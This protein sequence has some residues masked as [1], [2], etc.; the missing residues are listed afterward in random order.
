MKTKLTTIKGHSS[1]SGDGDNVAHD[2]SMPIDREPLV[3]A[4]VYKSSASHAQIDQEYAT[5]PE[6][7]KIEQD[8]KAIIKSREQQTIKLEPSARGATQLVEGQQSVSPQDVLE[9]PRRALVQSGALLPPYDPGQMVHLFEHSNSLR[10]NVDA[11]K[12]NIDGF[13]HRLEPTINLESDDLET[14]ISTAMF[15]DRVL[16]GDD[17][18][19]APSTEE[20][21][22]KIAEIKQQ[23]AI[24]KI[25]LDFFFQNAVMNESFITLR[26]KT[27]QDQEI[28]G[29]AYWEVLRDKEGNIAQFILVPSHTVRLN[30]QGP[31]LIPIEQNVQATAITFTKRVSRRRFRTFVQNIGLNSVF[32]KEFGDPRIISAKTGM[33]WPSVEGMQSEEGADAREANEVIHFAVHSTRSP[34]GVPRWIGALLAVLGSRQAE[35]VNFLYFDNKSVPPMAMIVTGGRVT[36]DTEARIRDFIESEVKGRNSFHNILILEAETDK[37][38][39]P[40]HTGRMKIE[41][42]PL[43]QAIHNDALFQNYDKENIQK[44]GQSFRL[45][46]LLRGDSRDFNRA[47]ATAVLKFTEKQIFAPERNCF[48][49]IINRLILNDLGVCYHRFKSLSPKTTDPEDMAKVISILAKIGALVPRDARTLAEEVLNTELKRIDEPWMDIPL[50][51]AASGRIAELLDGPGDLFDQETGTSTQTPLGSDPSDDVSDEE[52]NAQVQRI[53]SALT[54]DALATGGR[55]LP[56][57][58]SN[59]RRM[60]ASIFS[61]GQAKRRAKLL[62][63]V[64]NSLKA[65]ELS[66]REAAVAEKEFANSK[67]TVEPNGEPTDVLNIKVPRDVWDTFNIIPE[68]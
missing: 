44:V 12:T 45:P 41:L 50:P 58:G 30:P 33:A 14:Q 17:N 21:Q 8:Q 24:E 32:L 42:K 46:P 16:G 9:S 64:R 18:P 62:V 37:S 61:N 48:D 35:E 39:G 10:Q 13:G 63:D 54:S 52:N 5:E 36:K 66:S 49:D 60:P 47:T 59:L 67:D 68:E 1:Q 65:Q 40:E 51:L 43:T 25:K 19:V 28:T 23:M 7:N 6:F 31:A 55:K 38:S 53:L 56:A 4:V 27:R 29:N 15:Q 26:M 34:Y 2:I 22:S 57:Q 3:K 20:V 11:Y